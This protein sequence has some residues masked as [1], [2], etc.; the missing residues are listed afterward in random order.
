MYFVVGN[1]IQNPDIFSI[2]VHDC[3]LNFVN[4]VF[5]LV[6]WFIFLGTQHRNF[7]NMIE[8]LSWKMCWISNSNLNHKEGSSWLWYHHELCHYNMK[9]LIF[10]LCVVYV[11]LKETSVIFIGKD[12]LYSPKSITPCLTTLLKQN[13]KSSLLRLH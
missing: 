4:F 2:N 9:H 8:I 13:F 5:F 1:F 12:K 11:M 3:C 7:I 6:S 10:K